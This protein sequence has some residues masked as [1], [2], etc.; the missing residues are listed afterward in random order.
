MQQSHFYYNK[1]FKNTESAQLCRSPAYG[2]SHLCE[3]GDVV[4][5]RLIFQS[6]YQNIMIGRKEINTPHR[7]GFSLGEQKILFLKV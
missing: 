3:W 7:Q 2:S 5:T 4:V 6:L 1:N